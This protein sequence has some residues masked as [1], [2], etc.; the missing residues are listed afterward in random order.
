MIFFLTDGQPTEGEVDSGTIINNVKNANNKGFAIH[1]IAFGD[2]ADYVLLQ[3]ISTKNNGLARK[4]FEDSDAALQ[5][6]GANEKSY[7]ADAKLS[8]TFIYV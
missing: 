1:C 8:I 4:I 3:K 6:T 7:H 2:D 5:L